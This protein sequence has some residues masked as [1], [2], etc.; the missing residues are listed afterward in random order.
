M[1]LK[2]ST[3]RIEEHAPLEQYTTF[4]LGASC[5][6]MIHCQTPRQLEETIPYLI[7]EKK[8]FILIGGGSNLVVSDEPLD[9]Y[10]VRYYTD[11]PVIEQNG[12]TLT[13]S[14]STQL[15]HLAFFAAQRGLEG[16]NCTTGIP[17]SVG[18]AIVGNAGAWGKQ[19]GD[20]LTSVELISPQG[21]KKT[22][23]TEELQ[24][25]YRDSILKKTG[26]IVV[27]AVLS[28]QKGDVKALSEEREKILAER[29]SK[30]PDLRYEPCA[31]SFFRNIEPTSKAGKRQAAGWFLEEAGGKKL[32]VGGAVIYP[33]HANI[34]IKSDGCRSQDVYELSL[35]MARVVKEKFNLDLVR[36]VCFVGKFHG[37]PSDVREIIW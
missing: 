19:I 9:C 8:K 29:K 16:I 7:K 34:I 17:G 21:V 18:G 14:G 26:D 4:R 25:T 33:K 12:T 28:L 32:K 31:G 36:E 1:T 15:D 37:M 6:G 30:H 13:V 10:V 3:I 22:A 20:V 35:Q 5:E 27:S 11:K 24:F 2:N 23:R